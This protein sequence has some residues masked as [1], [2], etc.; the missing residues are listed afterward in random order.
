MRDTTHDKVF[1][2]V[3]LNGHLRK[4]RKK[5]DRVHGRYVFGDRKDTREIVLYFALENQFRLVNTSIRISIVGRD[6]E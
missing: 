4:D 3:N 2:G 1:S 5:Y 6:L